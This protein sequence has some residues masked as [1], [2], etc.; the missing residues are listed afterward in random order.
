VIILAERADDD[1][2]DTE[3]ATFGMMRT[4]LVEILASIRIAA[5]GLHEI[6]R[7]NPKMS[8]RDANLVRVALENYGSIYDVLCLDGEITPKE[9]ALCMRKIYAKA[10]LL[11]Q[12]EFLQGNIIVNSQK[13]KKPVIEHIEEPDELVKEILLCGGKL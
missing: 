7:T 4:D 13:T 5:S 1:N 2:H 10:D 9:V 11:R 12:M 8:Q 3:F 6:L